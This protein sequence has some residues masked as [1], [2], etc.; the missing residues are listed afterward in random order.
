MTFSRRTN[1]NAPVNRLTLARQAR[2]GEILDLTE[3]NPTRAAIDYP[4]DELSEIFA[5]A[6]RAP[7]TPD[8]LGLPSAREVLGGD[9]ILTASTSEAYSFLFKLL[10]D[11]SDEIVSMSMFGDQAQAEESDERA[12]QFI[13]EYLNRFDIDRTEVIGG[14]VLVS[15]AQARVLEPAHA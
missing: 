15:R 14:E 6:S 9:V 7:Y 8:P 12:L 3:S 10:C 1:W 5:R 11:P 13:A 4:L 2:A